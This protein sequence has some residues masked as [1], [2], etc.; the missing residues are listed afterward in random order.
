MLVDSPATRE[1]YKSIA[2][3]DVYPLQ[4]FGHR[5]CEKKDCTHL[6]ELSWEGYV[7]FMTYLTGL[8]K[9]HQPTEKVITLLKEAFNDPLMTPYLMTPYLMTP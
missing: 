5:W 9:L 1:K 6:A 4:F 3:T 8:P 2:E 7:K